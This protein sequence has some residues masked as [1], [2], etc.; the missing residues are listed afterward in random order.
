M[1]LVIVN[2]LLN[3]ISPNE[4]I[5]QEINLYLQK[6]LSNYS[7]YEYTIE[8]NIGSYKSIEINYQRASNRIGNNFFIPVTIIDQYGI[9]REK[10]LTVDI[11]IYE[12][13]LVA[14]KPIA[15]GDLLDHSNTEWK[16]KD[17]TELTQEPITQQ[18]NT[19][20]IISKYEIQPGEILCYDY[21]ENSPVL[22]VGDSIELFYAR[23]TVMINFQGVTRQSGAVGDIIKVRAN[24]K[25]YSAKIIN[26][27]EALIVE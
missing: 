2:I 9:E 1:L 23:G 16:K 5:N 10:F 14:T 20:E 21:V 25:Q 17:I 26:P 24:G 11:N 8:E 4:S 7:N 27:R 22:E 12:T 13:V 15:K 6:N 18:N 19:A 3:L